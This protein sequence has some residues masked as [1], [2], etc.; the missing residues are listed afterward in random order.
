MHLVHGTNRCTHSHTLTLVSW[1]P[2]IVLSESGGEQNTLC[3]W[4]L[5]FSLTLKHTQFFFQCISTIITAKILRT[6]QC[7]LNIC[8]SKS[9]NKCSVL[10]TPTMWQGAQW[11]K[12]LIGC[13]CQLVL[14]LSQRERERDRTWKML[15]KSKENIEKVPR[16]TTEL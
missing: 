11:V 15:I 10:F 6:L 5:F 1:G 13:G 9:W 8:V 16:T 12:L 2:P 7:F 14:E 3:H 4:C